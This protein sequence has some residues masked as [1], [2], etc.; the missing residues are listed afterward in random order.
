[1]VA[2]KRK[3][4]NMSAFSNDDV[5]EQR[6]HIIEDVV[7]AVRPDLQREFRD[8]LVRREIPKLAPALQALAK[9]EVPRL[10]KHRLL[11]DAMRRPGLGALRQ[12]PAFDQAVRDILNSGIRADLPERESAV[13]RA[14]AVLDDIAAAD[15]DGQGMQTEHWRQWVAETGDVHE[16]TLEE[17]TF[18]ACN[19]TDETTKAKPS[20]KAF[21]ESRLIVSEFRSRDRP[22]VFAPY[23]DPRNWPTCS[24]FW[25]SMEQVPSNN[26][27]PRGG[28]YD[29]SFEETVRILDE[30]LVV[31]LDVGVRAR[32]DR[33]RYWVRFNIGRPR[34]S[35]AVPVE[36]D[37]GTVSAEWLPAEGV[38]LVK[39]TKFLYFRPDRPNFADLSCDFGWCEFMVNMA[40]QCTVAPTAGLP[41]AAAVASTPVADVDDA[42]REF[43]EGVTGECAEGIGQYRP[44][45]Q[46]LIG[47]FTGPSW[48]LRWINDL[49]DMGK[50]T[51]DRY[52]GIAGQVRRFADAL[53]NADVPE[54]TDARVNTE[55]GGHG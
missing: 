19:D 22:E 52:G 54:G 41:A 39:A 45:L 51:V 7:L 21:A 10:L 1:M 50:V 11:L 27:R 13:N 43:A 17:T 23:V 38:T 46:Q 36:V 47:R 25:Q 9:S 18:E 24:S 30:D 49:L 15:G 12:D 14:K 37:T 2:Q 20:Y 44:H 42:V 4:W 32:P 33:S 8:Q 40:Y 16:F 31:P 34:F 5:K 53:S 48:D 28:G 6:R 26:L 35:A 55:D 29:C 3:E